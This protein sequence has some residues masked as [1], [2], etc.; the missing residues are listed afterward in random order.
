MN[1]K[2]I[3]KENKVYYKEKLLKKISAEKFETISFTDQNNQTYIRC[4]K[5]KKGIW[6]FCEAGKGLVKFLTSDSDNFSFLDDNYA[7]DSYNVFF[8]C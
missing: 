7:R 3:I 8:S 1:K 6:Y 4:L 2:F 5:D